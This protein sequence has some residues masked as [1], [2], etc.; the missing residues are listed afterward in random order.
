[1]ALRV[2]TDIERVKT[3]S[4]YFRSRS[5]DSENPLPIGALKVNNHLTYVKPYL[6]VEFNL[7][8]INEHKDDLGAYVAYLEQLE[9]LMGYLK[10][11]Q[12]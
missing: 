7:T 10:K 9:E 3:V 11:N 1:M 2:K 4:D 6:A 5:C 8:C 12:L